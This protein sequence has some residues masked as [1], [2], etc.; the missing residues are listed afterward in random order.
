MIKS[1]SDS[2]KYHEDASLFRDAVIATAREHGF[3]TSLVEKDY[4]CSLLLAYLCND[5]KTSMVF[6]GGTALS[7]VYT[8][9]YRLSEDLDFVI[10]VQIDSARSVRSK[11]AKPL[12]SI[13]DGIPE[14]F[15]N[16]RIEESLIGHN[17]S[18]QYIAFAAYPSAVAEQ[19]QHI[20]IE[21]GLREE[22]ER[23]VEQGTIR[24]LLRDPFKKTPVLP[25]FHISVM[26]FHE[27]YAEKVRAALTRRTP[28][29]RDF[30]DIF[31]AVK[32]LKLDVFEDQFLKLVSKKL[33]VPD[34]GP[35]DV[36]SPKKKLLNT[37]MEVELRS[38]LN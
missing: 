4:Y 16:M 29:I 11:A 17:N 13:I 34:N 36:S 32:T 26:A 22:I 15:P 14:V 1:I 31:H 6:K 23:P 21:I 37:Q 7:K 12:K 20:K 18:K 8:D 5:S 30:F 38:V 2:C 25:E 27:T 33:K 10:P 28:A 3:R 9:F 24:T 35:V 19:A